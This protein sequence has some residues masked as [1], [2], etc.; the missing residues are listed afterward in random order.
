MKQKYVLDYSVQT[1]SE[2]LLWHVVKNWDLKINIL[3]AKVSEGQVGN[4][5]VELE[6]PSEEI[7]NEAIGWLEKRGVSCTPVSKRLNWKEEAC[8]HCGACTAVCFSGALSMDR[9]SWQL[10][11]DAT[12]CTAC[13]L[14]IKACPMATFSLDFG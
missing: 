2:P 8:I 7:F 6:H 14:C 9:E 11:V 5:L 13:E 3:R 10:Q 12:R 1:T 4:L